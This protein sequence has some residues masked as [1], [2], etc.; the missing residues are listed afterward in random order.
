MR[1][2]HRD[3]PQWRGK[4][5][6]APAASPASALHIKTQQF[7]LKIDETSQ[8]TCQSVNSTCQRPVN[9]LNGTCKRPANRSTA[10]VNDL[11][12]SSMAPV[13]DLSICQQHLSKTCQS[14]Q[15]HLSNCL[16]SSAQ[17]HS[18]YSLLRKLADEA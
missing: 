2:T 7:D 13:K 12:I 17:V 3:H 16:S 9:Q 8:P 10:P 5:S 11:S 6:A 18:S 1:K 15:W 14:V 4:L